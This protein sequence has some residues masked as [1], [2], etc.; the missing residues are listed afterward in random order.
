MSITIGRHI[1][2]GPYR[3]T[4]DLRDQSGVYAII[5]QRTNGNF[6]LDVGESAAVKS[7]IASHDRVDSWSKCRQGVLGVA[8]CYTPNAQQ[9]GRMAIE[10][11]IRNQFNPPCGYR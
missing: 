10:Q 3:T 2:E 6:V 1:F 7:R 5:D 9:F 4:N 11:E 8:V